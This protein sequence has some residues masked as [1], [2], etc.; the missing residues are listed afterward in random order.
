LIEIMQTQNW[1][2]DQ[3]IR[4]R[5]GP[6]HART[7][8]RM[9]PRRAPGR[10]A[11]SPAKKRAKRACTASGPDATQ[12]TLVGVEGVVHLVLPHM[13]GM[14]GLMGLPCVS[15]KA[16]ALK[17][18]LGDDWFDLVAVLAARE[19]RVLYDQQASAPFVEGQLHYHD[20]HV[21][22][23]FGVPAFLTMPPIVVASA[24]PSSYVESSKWVLA[25]LGP[26]LRRYAATR[27]LCKQRGE[28]SLHQLVCDVLV[29]RRA[30]HD[31]VE[32]YTQVAHGSMA[33]SVKDDVMEE[34]SKRHDDVAQSLHDLD[35]AWKV[36]LRRFVTAHWKIGL[37]LCTTN[38]HGFADQ[39][40]MSRM[41]RPARPFC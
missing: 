20:K 3:K 26:V 31:A 37:Q 21:R 8:A 5:H 35:A 11:K 32:A 7:T 25:S 4:T 6:A 38:L 30:H 14:R 10:N 36:S 40:F 24:V 28:G 23:Y 27:A 41:I 16:H 18:A 2:P 17:L 1:T 9:P 12:A 22:N 34:L 29:C 39:A 13:T 15:H 33:H 19:R